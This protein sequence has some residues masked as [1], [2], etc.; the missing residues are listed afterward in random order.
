MWDFFSALAPKSRIKR[1]SC[2]SPPSLEA[3]EDRYCPSG[4]SLE[5]GDPTLASFNGSN[6]SSPQ[7]GLI[8]DSSG[9]LYGTTSAGGANTDGTVFEVAQG[10]GTITTLAS[11]SGANGAGPTDPLITDSSGN[12]YGT[13]TGGGAF[14]DGTVFELAHGSG[15]ITTLASFD[16]TNGSD[17]VAAL[18][19]DGSGNLYSTTSAGGAGGAGTVFE[20]AHG[21]GTITTLASF[22][23]TNGRQ[24]RDPLVM[25]GSGN[26]YGTT[27]FGGANRR[28]TVFEL[29]YGSSTITTLASFNGSAGSYPLSGLL[30]DSGGNLYGTTFIGGGVFELAHGSGTITLLASFNGSTGG[31]PYY[32]PLVMDSSGNLYGTTLEAGPSNDGTVFEL[33]HGSGTI[34]TLLPFNGP[35]GSGPIGLL[36]DSSG[37]LY[38][39]TEYGGANGLGTVFEVQCGGARYTFSGFSSATAG[40]TGQFT[41]TVQNPDGSTDTGYIGTIHFTSSDS[42]AV[43][44]AAYTFTAGDAGMH[45]FSATLDTA[46]SQFITGF[47]TNSSIVGQ[48]EVTVTAAAVSSLNISGYP[49]STVAGTSNSFTATAYDPYGNVATGYLGT[50]SFS[51]SDA[52][53]GLPANYT[54]QASDNGTHTFSAVL[55][56]AGSQSITATDTSN[57]SVTGTQSGITVTAAAATHFSITA[58]L[59]VTH[60][61]AFSVTI[62]ALDAY[63]NVATG[64]LGT[65]KF[66]SSDKKAGLPRNYTFTAGDAGVHVFSVTLNTIGLEWLAVTDTKHSSI[67]DKDSNIQV[68]SASFD[69]LFRE[70]MPDLDDQDA[71]P[72]LLDDAPTGLEQAVVLRDTHGRSPGEEHD[73]RVIPVLDAFRSNQRAVE[74]LSMARILAKLGR[75]VPANNDDELGGRNYDAHLLAR[76]IPLLAGAALLKPDKPQESPAKRRKARRR[77]DQPS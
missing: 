14:G 39:T 76:A 25:D 57:S 15:A 27:Q 29:A 19:M 38:G 66:T 48:I 18:I 53:A 63:G 3:L 8:M 47:D 59:A 21:S 49:S 11:F 62:T 16:G 45:T 58:P 6:G 4:G 13:T 12:F 32:T 36:M 35:N 1:P 31:D 33:A 28:G 56:T 67:T 17:P 73:E 51:S 9:N 10:S 55:K 60:G 64:Y 42:K 40:Q 44:P 77:T 22:N 41:V 54:F 65:V 52:Q 20:L 43:L 46:G 50:V 61:V 7:C 23:V 68:V 2:S 5:W 37:N 69:E 70:G 74:A 72:N 34:T 75:K 24:P 26:L 30:M 71:I